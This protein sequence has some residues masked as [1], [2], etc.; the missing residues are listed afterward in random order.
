MAHPLEKHVGRLK[1]EKEEERSEAKDMLRE[2]RARIQRSM[3]DFFFT[4]QENLH[5]E[6]PGQFAAAKRITRIVFFH[7]GV[8][9]LRL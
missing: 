6:L 3:P 9:F 4:G 1:G 7:F 2:P 5:R 8:L